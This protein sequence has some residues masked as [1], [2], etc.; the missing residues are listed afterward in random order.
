M[1]KFRVDFAIEDKVIVELKAI[2]G[3]LAKIFESQVISY[4]KASK[5]NVGL[6]VNFGNRRCEIR[7]LMHSI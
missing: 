7:R 2:E 4:L 6:L 3:K 5:L 1:G